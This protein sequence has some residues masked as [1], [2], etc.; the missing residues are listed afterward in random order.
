MIYGL[1]TVMTDSCTFAG[2]AEMITLQG[3]LDIATQNLPNLA[4]VSCWVCEG[5]NCSVGSVYGPSVAGLDLPSNQDRTVLNWSARFGLSN[6][7]I[8]GTSSV[9]LS[10]PAFGSYYCRLEVQAVAK[11]VDSTVAGPPTVPDPFANHPHARAQAGT[12]LVTELQGSL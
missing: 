5:G 7:A 11:G 8:N 3:S 2:G 10:T 9:G 4:I 6:D 12:T 1:A